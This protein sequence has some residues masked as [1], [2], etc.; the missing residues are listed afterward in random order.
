MQINIAGNQSM[1]ICSPDSG[2][3]G[4]QL[5]VDEEGHLDYCSNRPPHGGLF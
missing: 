1:F 5:V 4:V 3:K 2:L